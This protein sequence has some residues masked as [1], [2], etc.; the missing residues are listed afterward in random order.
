MKALISID[1]TNDF[2]A[3]NGAL[4]VGKPA[5][6]ILPRMLHIT[7]EFHHAGDLVVYAI[8]KHEKNDPHHPESQLF[9]AHNIEGEQGRALYGEYQT[10]YEEL[11]NSDRIMYMDKTRYSAF[12]GTTLDMEL[13]ARGIKEV[14]LIGVCT[15]IC[16]LHTAI[17][18]YNL[19]YSIV[20]HED[21]VASFNEVGHKWTL[22]HITNCL[23]GKVLTGFRI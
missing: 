13:R 19:G 20:V 21:T 12:C 16:V 14:H 23:G 9:P 15:D 4:T 18:A 1:F 6:E 7:K 3:D 17:E 10:Q 22:E 5:Q 8:D 2:V 11:K